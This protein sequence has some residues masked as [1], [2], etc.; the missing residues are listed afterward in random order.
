LG[1]LDPKRQFW[2]G[3]FGGALMVMFKTWALNFK[4]RLLCGLW[5]LFPVVSGFVSRM[6][7]PHHPLIA[8]YEGASAPVI[9]FVMAR[10]MPM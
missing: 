7:E 9:F 10:S 4:T 5:V 2:W 8:V 6:C 1:T 3:F